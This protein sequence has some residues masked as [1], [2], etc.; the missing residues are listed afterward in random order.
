MPTLK[1]FTKV[2]VMVA[3]SLFIINSVPQLRAFTKQA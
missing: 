3:V 2:F 1:S